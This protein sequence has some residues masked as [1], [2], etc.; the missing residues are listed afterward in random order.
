VCSTLDFYTRILSNIRINRIKALW[1]RDEA[2]EYW[3]P[4]KWRMLSMFAETLPCKH[5]PQLELQEPSVTP[6]WAAIDRRGGSLRR[7]FRA[8]YCPP[9]VKPKTDRFGYEITHSGDELIERNRGVINRPAPNYATF[10]DCPFYTSNVRECRC[11]WPCQKY[12]PDWVERVRALVDEHTELMLR[13][14][15]DIFHMSAEQAKEHFQRKLQYPPRG[16]AAFTLFNCMLKIAQSGVASLTGR[17]VGVIR[18]LLAGSNTKRGMPGDDIFEAFWSK[19]SSLRT[20]IRTTTQVCQVVIA[21]LKTLDQT[22]GCSE[23]LMATLLAP[24]DAGPIPASVKKKLVACEAN[25]LEVLVGKG[26]ITSGEVLAELVPKVMAAATATGCGADMGLQRIIYALQVAFSRRRSLLLLNLQSQVRVE[27]LPWAQV[28]LDACAKTSDTRLAAKQTL[29]GIVTLYYKAFPQTIM[30]NKLLQSVRVL[31][32]KAGLED[33]CPI[34]EELAVDIFEGRFS[35]K[36]VAA[37]RIAAS[38]LSGSIY[39]RYYDVQQFFDD[40]LTTTGTVAGTP[41]FVNGAMQRVGVGTAD[42]FSEW[43][44]TRASLPPATGR[45][46]Y[47]RPAENGQIVEQQQIV[48]THN[49]ASFFSALGLKDKLDCFDLSRRT[50]QWIVNELNNFPGQYLDMLRACKNVAYAWRQLLFYSSFVGEVGA[51]TD[52]LFAEKIFVE[53]P[54]TLQATLTALILNPLMQ[55]TRANDAAEEQPPRITP[56][57]AWVSTRHPLM[58]PRVDS[59][60]QA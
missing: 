53:S 45:H 29:V 54:P 38:L 15:R 9:H 12:P 41:T 56:L 17:E 33:K 60:S 14:Y 8:T 51:V 3:Q 23:A 24:C 47:R 31:V 2:V 4:L 43:C 36:F 59:E 46:G 26:M 7:G 11:G 49:L 20:G 19:M 48:T 35:N 39:A 42:W 28:V 6:D 16:G 10:P 22:S 30:V 40:V 57:L 18:T 21:R 58:P 27:E 34:T 32:T 25:S 5:I 44:V 52:M 1:Q 13:V 50:W 55:I 37:S